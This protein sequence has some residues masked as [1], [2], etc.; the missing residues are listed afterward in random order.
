MSAA[1]PVRLDTAEVCAIARISRATLWRRIA[2]GRLPAPVDR[3]RRALF[4][5]DAVFSALLPAAGGLLRERSAE[6]DRAVAV[7]LAQL[8]SLRD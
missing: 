3:G 7:R 4:D 2:A 6:A 8:R 5:A 1:P